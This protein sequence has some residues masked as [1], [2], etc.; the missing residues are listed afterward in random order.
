MKISFNSYFDPWSEQHHGLENFKVIP[1]Y[2]QVAAVIFAALAG[3]ASFGI[4][5]LPVFRLLTNSSI[6]TQTLADRVGKVWVQAIHPSKKVNI[7]DAKGRTPLHYAIFQKDLSYVD[8]LVKKGA[9]INKKD[10]KGFT[11]LNFA[12]MDKNVEMFNYFIE[13]GANVNNK[14][15]LGMTPLV[16]AIGE[17]KTPFLEILLR[18]GA[19]LENCDSRGHSALH[20]ACMDGNI[21]ALRLLLQA[22]ACPDLCDRSGMSPLALARIKRVENYEAIKELFLSVSPQSVS[23]ENEFLQRHL[24]GH[25]F[26]LSCETHFLPK[27]GNTIRQAPSEASVPI[28]L[29]WEEIEKSFKE[30]LAERSDLLGSGTQKVL[31]EALEFAKNPHSTSELFHRWKDHKPV[32]IETGYQNHFVAAVFY[33]DH[34]ILVNR[35]GGSE[36]Q[37]VRVEKIRKE[38][39][40]AETFTSIQNLS[41]KEMGDYVKFMHHEFPRT[42]CFEQ[43]SFERSLESISNRYID[44]QTANNCAWAN[45]EGAAVVLS[46]MLG[47]AEG[48]SFIAL[49]L[50]QKCYFAENYLKTK[51]GEEHGYYPSPLLIVE[52]TSHLRLEV[53]KI[54]DP[55]TKRRVEES[56]KKLE[57]EATALQGI[58]TDSMAPE[59]KKEWSRELKKIT[60]PPIYLG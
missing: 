24:I 28:P 26:S 29:F 27:R 2:Q 13:N 9:D 43:T 37:R 17:K 54:S 12:M 23:Y 39:I 42:Y 40:T 35:G 47:E 44:H 18:K 58:S 3:A 8:S 20:I 10:H 55:Q 53:N 14:D 41:K 51:K 15:H 6:P 19:N 4:F 11:A 34:L 32:F 36:G 38:R 46:Q 57:D 30:T 33:K 21:D 59:V 25:A 52:M 48:S 49:P 31:L 5:A 50:L 60:A 45:R 56:I 16:Y 22:G 7:P 1:R